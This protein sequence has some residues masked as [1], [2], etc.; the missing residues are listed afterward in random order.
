MELFIKSC[1]DGLLLFLD[2]CFGR[3]EVIYEYV[4]V[5]EDILELSDSGFRLSEEFFM[6]FIFD[7][8]VN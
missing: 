1:K 8:N 5:C 6:V 3:V 2:F 4:C 7:L